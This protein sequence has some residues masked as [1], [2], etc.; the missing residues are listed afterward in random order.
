MSA[1]PTETT[2]HPVARGFTDKYGRFQVA[3][4]FEED[5]FEAVHALATASNIS[6]ASMVRLLVRDGIKRRAAKRE[7]A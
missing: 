1:I 5:T 4:R 7:V 3:C 2:R 6:F